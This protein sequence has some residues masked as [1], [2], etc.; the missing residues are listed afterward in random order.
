MKKIAYLGS[1][2]QGLALLKALHTPNDQWRV[3]HP[4]DSKDVRSC[5]DAFQEYA[6]AQ[7]LDLLVAATPSA[8]DAMLADF[9]PDIV[10][11]CGWYWLLK[12]V[13]LSRVP[14][15][16]WGAHNSL[17]PKYRGASPLVWAMIRGEVTV[18]STVFRFTPKMDDGPVL[19]QVCTEVHRND[20]VADVLERIQERLVAELPAKWMALLKDEAVLTE[21]AE[22]EATYCGQ[23]VPDDGRIDWTGTAAE[24]RN[25]I[26]AQSRPY[27]GAFTFVDEARVTLWDADEDSRIWYGTVGQ[28]LAR[29]PNHVLIQC[30]GNT[31]LQ[32]IRAERDG[33]PVEPRKAF[34]TIGLRVI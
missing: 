7:M 12:P 4:E 28:V 13:V 8:T 1:K 14:M 24:I 9:A 21:Q 25:F 31:A 30:G 6:R 10:F 29:T 19:H 18:G 15:G 2:P 23:R 32:V 16:F 20:H 33:L 27:P 26:R 17:L 11:V 22:R 5:L 3:I 34:P